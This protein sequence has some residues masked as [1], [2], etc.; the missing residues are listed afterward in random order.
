MLVG[1]LVVIIGLL[2]KLGIF[3]WIGNLPGDIQFKRGG[4]R[5]YFPITSMILVSVVLSA[6]FSLI[7]RFF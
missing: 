1:I 4:F 2:V 5:V 3:G 6:L 7:R